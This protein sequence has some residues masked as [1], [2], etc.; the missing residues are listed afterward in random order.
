MKKI[1]L[2]Q[3]KYALVDDGDFDLL[4][5]HNWYIS[6]HGYATSTTTPHLYMHILI[7]KTPKGKITDH[8]NR[9]TLDN[10]RKNLRTGDKRLN[11]INRGIQ[12]NNTSGHRGLSWM[13]KIKKWETYI[14]NHNKK[15]GLGFYKFKKEA[16][17]I[18]K[19][20]ELKYHGI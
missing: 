12:S 5:K 16:I 17:S 15:I 9:N 10:R 4:K 18:R 13:P 11:S 7:N 6:S 1:K 8:I 20:A 19:G 14:W 3:G 2:T